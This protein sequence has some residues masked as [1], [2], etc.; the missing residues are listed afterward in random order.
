MVEEDGCECAVARVSLALSAAAVPTSDEVLDIG[1]LQGALKDLPDVVHRGDAEVEPCSA[2]RGGVAAGRNPRSYRPVAPF[3]P[4]FVLSS[5][6]LAVIVMPTAAPFEA[7]DPAALVR[8]E[9]PTTK[10]KRK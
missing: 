5:R 3:S 9:L 4:L 2:G 8:P 10:K 6:P 7:A 1:L